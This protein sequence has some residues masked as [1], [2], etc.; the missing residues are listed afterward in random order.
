MLG[1]MFFFIAYSGLGYVHGLSQSADDSKL[2]CPLNKVS[3]TVREICNKYI[4]D[5]IIFSKV[6]K[7]DLILPDNI[8]SDHLISNKVNWYCT[9]TGNILVINDLQTQHLSM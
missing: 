5:Y 9:L 3:F 1:I 4:I 7:L 2:W 6:G 8:T